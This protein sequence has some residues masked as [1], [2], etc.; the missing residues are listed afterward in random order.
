MP[1]LSL[2][3]DE[4]ELIE[5]AD[6]SY[7]VTCQQLTLQTVD[8][9]LDVYAEGKVSEVVIRCLCCDGSRVELIPNE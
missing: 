1:F 3:A 4:L 7:C 8:E 9:V 2:P 6:L 5:G